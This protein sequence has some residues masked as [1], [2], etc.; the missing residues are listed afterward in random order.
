MKV[1]GIKQLDELL[2][3]LDKHWITEF[4]GDFDLVLRV[5]HYTMVYKSS[6]N[7]VYVVFNVEFGGIDTLY[8]VKLCRIFDCKLDNIVISRAFRLN[9]AVEILE[10]LASKNDSIVLLAFPYNYLPFN[11]AKYTEATRVTGI[12]AKIA[13]FNQVILFNTVSKHGNHMPEGGSFHHH[14]V[15]VIVKLKQSRGV[16][17]AELLKHPVKQG[18]RRIFTEK[19]LDYPLHSLKQRTI[20]D[21]FT[22]TQYS[23]D[24][25]L[26][27]IR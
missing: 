9:D 21:W 2:N 3:P 15:K 27:S 8:L 23:P 11:P 22:S 24:H 20:L 19:T 25:A 18:G 6:E 16:V 26:M 12:I 10:D 14:V 7:T 17:Y 4:Y 1:T 13:A 5:M